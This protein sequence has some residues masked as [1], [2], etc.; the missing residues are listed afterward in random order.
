MLHNLQRYWIVFEPEDIVVINRSKGESQFERLD[1]QRLDAWLEEYSISELWEKNVLGVEALTVVR[2]H[3]IVEG[4]TEETFVKTMLVEYLGYHNIVV[5][6]RLVETSR[7]KATIYR[8]GMTNYPKARKD[9]ERW[10][11]EDGNSDA[12]FTTMFDLY[13]LPDDFPEYDASKINMDPYDRVDKFFKAH[14]QETSITP[15]LFWYIQLHEF[16]ALLFSEPAQF[17]VVFVEE[18]QAVRNL[19]SVREGFKSPE[20]IDDGATTAPFETI[21]SRRSRH[22]KVK[23][24]LL[25]P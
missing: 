6:V 8:G 5:D 7:R 4:Q 24:P 16:E 9:L 13:R 14:L 20:L 10:M 18:R 22:T 1:P 23:R 12:H 25:G 2:L 19:Q 21:S 15:G 3:M 11:K 17:H